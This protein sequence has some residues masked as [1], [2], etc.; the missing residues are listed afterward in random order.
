MGT[1]EADFRG[2][3]LRGVSRSLTQLQQCNGALPSDQ[4]RQ[5]AWMAL[6]YALDLPE[7]WPTTLDLLLRLAP[8][9]VQAGH[10]YVW[11]PFLARGLAYSQT[12]AAR[13]A[14]G[15]LRAEIGWLQQLLGNLD[16]ARSQLE[17]ACTWLRRKGDPGRLATALDRLAE[18][19]RQQRRYD[20]CQQLIAELL[21]CVAADSPNAAYGYF[22]LGKAAFDQLQ[23]VE[24]EAHFHRALVIWRPIDARHT[25]LCIQ[26]LGRLAWRRTDYTAAIANFE[27]AITIFGEQQDVANR[28]L[29]QMNLGVVY[30]AQGE[31]RAALHYYC[32]AITVFREIGHTLHLAMAYNNCGLAYTTIAQ[33]AEAEEYYRLS[34][35]LWAKLG[36]TKSIADPQIGLAT[37]YTHQARLPEALDLFAA[38]AQQLQ[39][40]DP[41]QK[42]TDLWLE[43]QTNWDVA[44]RLAA[45]AGRDK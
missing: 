38:A 33:W 18:V 20:E 35:A 19:A 10:R 6:D 30:W 16:E 9:L 43:L 29:A 26:N 44:K 3:V 41:L 11:L 22:V 25:G 21:G 31:I 28:A 24:A 27:E 7:A 36:D 39:Q 14:E 1:Y 13:E 45:A 2:I 15:A 8:K 40:V 17:Q 5:R 34:I 12:I 4:L 42:D 32:E 37:V 23:W